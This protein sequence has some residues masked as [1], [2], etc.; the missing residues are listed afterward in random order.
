MDAKR[1]GNLEASQEVVREINAGWRAPPDI[2]LLCSDPLMGGSRGNTRSP[3]AI[4][5]S[6]GAT[7]LQLISSR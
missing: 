7:A 3:G 2:G 4:G 5:S 1:V 6:P